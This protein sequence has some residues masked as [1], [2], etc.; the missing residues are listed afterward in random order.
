MQPWA[1]GLLG[2]PGCTFLFVNFTLW[3]VRSLAV[4]TE[5]FTITERVNSKKLVL[6]CWS[7]LIFF[8]YS[9]QVFCY[10]CMHTS[11]F[12]W[13]FCGENCFAFWCIQ[14]GSACCQKKRQQAASIVWAH[15]PTALYPGKLKWT[16][17]CS[18]FSISRKFVACKPCFSGLLGVLERLKVTVPLELASQVL[19][20][21][22][23]VVASL[24]KILKRYPRDN[25]V[26][27][28]ASKAKRRWER[29]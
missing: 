4:G 14:P 1:E 19:Q 23:G 2:F 22:L 29:R 24:V 3:E 9:S 20:H 6:P 8:L 25:V 21:C 11:N 7:Y 5:F 26:K 13:R 12:T 18:L 17:Y 16:S 10:T 27:L 15:S 28:A